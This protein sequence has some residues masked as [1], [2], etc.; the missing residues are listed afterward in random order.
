M[1]L[2]RYQLSSLS[3]SL[4]ACAVRASML[5]MWSSTSRKRGCSGHCAVT[6][7]TQLPTCWRSQEGSSTSTAP[8]ISKAW[9]WHM[10]LV[11]GALV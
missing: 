6:G 5:M 7:V 1:G 2:C 8:G 10:L 4:R 11:Q 9:A 3:T